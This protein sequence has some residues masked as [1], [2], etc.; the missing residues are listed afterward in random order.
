MAE[1]APCQ[2]DG[3]MASQWNTLIDSLYTYSA[4][5]R[6]TPSLLSYAQ[7]TWRVMTTLP[8]H[9]TFIT[10][11]VI[12][13]TWVG[14]YNFMQVTLLACI[15]FHTLDWHNKNPNSKPFK[16]ICKTIVEQ[17]KGPCFS[18]L[19]LTAKDVSVESIHAY[20]LPVKIS[21]LGDCHCDS[22]PTSCQLRSHLS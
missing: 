11:P 1:L 2:L 6:R 7:P 8:G 16:I 20:K 13:K 12:H 22:L 3:L 19:N 14:T 10:D 5:W 4:E 17:P 21:E 9:A 15:Y 18:V